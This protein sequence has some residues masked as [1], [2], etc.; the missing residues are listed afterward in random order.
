MTPDEIAAYYTQRG[1][2][3]IDGYDRQRILDS[4]RE[5]RRRYAHEDASKALDEAAAMVREPFERELGPSPSAVDVLLNV[6]FSLGPFAHAGMAGTDVLNV[7]ARL[8]DDLSH[9]NAD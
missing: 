4:I 6:A 9:A 5:S 3:A 2:V 1:L 7:I 8:A